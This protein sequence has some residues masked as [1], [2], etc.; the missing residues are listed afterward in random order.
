MVGTPFVAFY[1]AGLI[2]GANILILIKIFLLLCLYIVLNYAG[3]ILYDD[4]LMVLLPL[5][6]YLAT[7]MWMYFTWFIY[8]M[9]YTSLLTNFVFL[10]SSGAL[11]YCFL[12]SWLGDAGVIST[13]Q[14]VR[15]RV[16]NYKHCILIHLM[17][18]FLFDNNFLYYLIK[19]FLL[20]FFCFA[21][22]KLMV[23][24]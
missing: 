15:L 11:W 2:L 18:C 21:L 20:G 24:N 14:E 22:I 19:R 9:P 23:I 1:F 3:Q 12:K 16:S 4:R 5:S 13:S 7:K 8:I 10:S 6:I 17:L